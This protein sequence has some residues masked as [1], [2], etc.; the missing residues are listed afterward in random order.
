M[1]RKR[2]KTSAR[3]KFAMGAKEIQLRDDGEIDEASLKPAKIVVPP[4]PK[5]AKI[6]LAQAAR[7]YL[8]SFQGGAL[9]FKFNKKSQI[10][11]LRNCYDSEKV[12]DNYFSI[13]LE[14]LAGLKGKAR[15]VTL[16]AAKQIMEGKQPT[17]GT[18][19]EGEPE[20]TPDSDAKRE[21]A[22]QI[23]R[24]LA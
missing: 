15:E 16:S 17:E 18:N 1:T 10:F 8:D 5:K 13:F 3:E 11:L 21:R 14:Y 20:V 2:N 23:A 7:D 9:S 24:V 19:E 4:A 6:D 22:I 12:P